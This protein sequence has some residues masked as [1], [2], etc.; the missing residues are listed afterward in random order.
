MDVKGN[1]LVRK[2]RLTSTSRNYNPEKFF[3]STMIQK[4]IDKLCLCISGAS[5][6]RFFVQETNF[7][8][9]EWILGISRYRASHL[10]FYN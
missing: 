9:L 4:T 7:L 5:L 1:Q 6:S 8:G 10:V 3:F 2:V